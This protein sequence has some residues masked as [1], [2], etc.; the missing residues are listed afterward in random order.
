MAGAGLTVAVTGPTGDLGISIVD[1]LERSRTVDRVVGM[2]RRPFDPAERGWRKTEYRQGDVTDA[3]SVKDLV[4]GADVVVHLAFAILSA[5]DATRELNVTGS[6]MVFESA[7]KSG[8][9]RICYASSVAAYGFHD[10]NPEWLTEDCPA[11]GMPE[12]FYSEQKAEV[13]ALLAEVLLRHERTTAYVFRPCSVGGP[14]AQLLLDEIPYIR[15]SE[16]MPGAVRSLLSQMPAL[17]PVIPDPGTRFQLVHEDDVAS[18][19]LA[20]VEGKGEPGPY[21][22]AGHGALTA[23]NLATALGWYS[24][25]VPEL[26]VDVTAEVV[27]RLPLP[28]STSWIHSARRSVL[29][30]TDRAQT[31]LGWKP[32][33]TSKQALREMVN[34]RRSGEL[35][36]R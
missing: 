30:K 7:V 15:L 5:S 11:R 19:F 14:N 21:N 8:V 9:K 10:D 2:A 12:H 22:L 18:A 13:E 31:R 28:A 3:E 33:F 26:A 27:S 32:E 16:A 23:S 34:A 1:A 35:T 17:K 20:G 29:M 4:K 25:P 36:A 24:V 6:R